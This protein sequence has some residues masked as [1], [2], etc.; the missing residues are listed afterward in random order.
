MC[1][2]ATASFISGTALSAIG[3]AS[4]AR[5]KT[6]SDLPYAI[7]PLLF[8]IQQLTEGVIWLTFQQD[9]P[10]L[11]QVMTYVYSVF[12]HTL[13]PIYV[14]FAIAVMEPV[15]WR[16][17]A[18]HV[19]LAIGLVA[20]LYQLYFLIIGPLEAQV[21]GKHIVYVSPHFLAVPMILFYLTATCVSSF[22][23]SHVFVRMFGGLVLLAFVA[24]YLVQLLALVSIWCFFAAALSVLIY[25]HIRY[26]SV[27]AMVSALK[28]MPHTR[29]A[30]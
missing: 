6:K 28:G 17:K 1:F 3:V 19:F 25:L 21:I 16:K 15:R 29:T 7:I 8:G 22:F 4:I 24:A 18:L 13:W 26:T 11:K 9:A 2:S 23:S 27:G 20:G 5:A 10:V 30:R 14:P 12:S